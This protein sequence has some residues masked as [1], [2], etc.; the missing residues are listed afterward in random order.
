MGWR[1]QTF[2]EKVFNNIL[3]G[4]RNVPITAYVQMTFYPD[5]EYFVL[6]QKRTAARLYEGGPYP[7]QVSG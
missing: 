1:R 3:K 4:S 6:K 2:P 5:N 7:T